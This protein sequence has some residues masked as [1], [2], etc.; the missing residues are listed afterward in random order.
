MTSD[1]NREELSYQPYLRACRR[2]I[3]SVMFSSIVKSPCA[4]KY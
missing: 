1:R 2:V 3:R 4:G